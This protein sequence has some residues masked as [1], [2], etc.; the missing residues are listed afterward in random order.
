LKL[1]NFF[2]FGMFRDSKYMQFAV[3]AK[4]KV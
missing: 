2:T 1:L 4:P 3:V